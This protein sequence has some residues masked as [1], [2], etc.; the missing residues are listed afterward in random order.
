MLGLSQK[1]FSTNLSRSTNIRAQVAFCL[2]AVLNVMA[3]HSVASHLHALSALSS[4]LGN[5]TC[6]ST[7][8]V[9]LCMGMSTSVMFSPVGWGSGALFWQCQ[10][11]QLL[12]KFSIFLE[13]A[14]E[15]V[16]CSDVAGG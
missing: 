4:L 12:R 11:I 13:G 1:A 5:I 10:Q 2:F 8:H 14:A 6:G 3:E 7:L 16:F 9:L 15:P